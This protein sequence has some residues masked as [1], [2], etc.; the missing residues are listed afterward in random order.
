MPAACQGRHVS[1]VTNRPPLF[2]RLSSLQLELKEN[3]MPT[4]APVGGDMPESAEEG[5]AEGHLIDVLC[6]IAVFILLAVIAH[7]VLR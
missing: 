7:V 2:D 1:S 6:A 4:Q 3:E 5:R